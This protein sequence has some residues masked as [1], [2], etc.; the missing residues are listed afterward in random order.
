MS[1]WCENVISINHTDPMMLEKFR[2]AFNEN[3]VAQ[4]FRPLEENENATDVWGTKS[5]LVQQHSLDP[6]EGF[7]SIW[8]YSED[9][10]PDELIKHLETDHGFSI[11]HEYHVPHEKYVGV[12]SSYED[13]IEEYPTTRDELLELAEDFKLMDIVD[14][15]TELGVVG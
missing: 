7:Q 13:F 4:T 10:P 6:D 12:Y 3:I 14:M 1:S 5:D 9:S 15:F 8:F 2:V 11:H